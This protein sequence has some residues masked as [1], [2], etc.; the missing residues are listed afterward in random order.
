VFPIRTFRCRR[1]LGFGPAYSLLLGI[2][3]CGFVFF[4]ATESTAQ[5]RLPPRPIPYSELDKEEGIA[6]LEEMRR[7]GVPGVYSFLF[8]LRYMPRR[9][10]E[11]RFRGQ[12]WGARNESGPVFRYELWSPGKEDEQILRFLVQNGPEPSVWTFDTA[13]PGQGVREIP[14]E[15][16]LTPVGEME[17][18]PFDLQMP[19]VYWPNFSYEGLS[20]V[21]G[22]SSHGFFM[23]PPA[24]F[25]AAHPELKGV[26]MFLDAEFNAMTGAELVGEG[27]Q[28]WLSFNII[29][30]KRVG[31]QWLVKTI[32]FLDRKDGDKTRLSVGAAALDLAP[33]RFRFSADALAEP[34]T[35]V[36]REDFTFF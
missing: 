27:D 33:E 23:K 22:R 30:I 9:G 31:D 2:L 28:V 15:E 4:G 7:M 24:E 10:K 11:K 3:L 34:F 20:R 14:I 21:R 36:P 16:L 26:R 19:F 13:A 35:S 1:A 5:R 18:T 32:D 29:E 25:A 17:F 6:R 12:M 8:E